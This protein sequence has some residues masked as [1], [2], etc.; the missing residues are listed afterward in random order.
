M[1]EPHK[2][3]SAPNG[4]ALDA[5]DMEVERQRLRTQ[6]VAARVGLLREVKALCLVV[7]FLIVGIALQFLLNQY[8]R[9]SLFF[10]V[11]LL[12]PFGAGFVFILFRLTQAWLQL[13][14]C[15]YELRA[16]EVIRADMLASSKGY[17][18]G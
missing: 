16:F 11:L 6:L 2:N 14:S 7:A 13:R 9:L 18:G 4:N 17:D 3:D 12:G 5:P 10:I 8:A 1:N 15:L